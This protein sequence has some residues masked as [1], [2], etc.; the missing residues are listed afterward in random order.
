MVD[1]CVKKKILKIHKTSEILTLE[2]ADSIALIL[3]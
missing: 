1:G 2:L 3:L